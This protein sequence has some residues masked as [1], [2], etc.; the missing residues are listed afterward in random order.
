M[1]R[2]G[3]GKGG[4][5]VA[6][7]IDGKGQDVTE[8]KSKKIRRRRKS[9]GR[10]KNKERVESRICTLVTSLRIA[11]SV[12][13]VV[14]LLSTL[15]LELLLELLELSLSS[16]SCHTTQEEAKMQLGPFLQSPVCH[17]VTLQETAS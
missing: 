4:F 15:L 7:A 2:E 3:K 1:G 14:V 12:L 6:V 11:G 13:L 16:L 9:D 10:K 17:S 8:T 5:A